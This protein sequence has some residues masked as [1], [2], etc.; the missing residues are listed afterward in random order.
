MSIG[1]IVGFTILGLIMG[2]LYIG[3]YLME[4]MDNTSKHTTPKTH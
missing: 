3:S 4:H 2:F 1:T